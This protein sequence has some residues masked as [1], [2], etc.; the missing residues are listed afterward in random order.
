MFLNYLSVKIF[1]GNQIWRVVTLINKRP[2]KL[3]RSREKMGRGYRSYWI[4]RLL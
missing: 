1:N 2:E 4:S 3:R